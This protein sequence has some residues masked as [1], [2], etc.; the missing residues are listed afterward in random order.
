[1]QISDEMLDIINDFDEIAYDVSKVEWR[2]SVT[3]SPELN[4]SAGAAAEMWAQG[5]TWDELVRRTKA[6]EGDLVRLLS[7]TGEALRQVGNL[8]SSNPEVSKIAREA[9]DSVLRDPIR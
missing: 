3:P 7:R 2:H 9:S 5:V 8:S 4:L 1:M 6:E